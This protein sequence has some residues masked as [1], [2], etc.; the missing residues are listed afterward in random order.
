VID[1]LLFLNF[2]LEC[3]LPSGLMMLEKGKTI[4]ESVYEQ[5]H[6]HENQLHIIYAHDLKVSQRPLHVNSVVYDLYSSCCTCSMQ[7]AI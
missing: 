1:E 4:Q 2:P 3:R 5:L 6:V 7:N